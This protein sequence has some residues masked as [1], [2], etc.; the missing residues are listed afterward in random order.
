MSA[1]KSQKVQIEFRDEEG[2]TEQ[3]WASPVGRSLYRLDNSPSFAY[4]VSHSDVV[5]ARKGRDGLLR[6][7]ETVEKSGNRTVRLLFA[8]FAVSSETAQPILEELQRL[9]CVYESLQPSM[10][11]INV[12]QEVELWQVVE[13]MKS[14]AMW[15]EHADPTYEELYSNAD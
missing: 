14:L 10:L 2:R 8:R 11:C 3:L 9:G 4:S 5:R 12:P 1:K 7:S 13:Y 6:F 15:W